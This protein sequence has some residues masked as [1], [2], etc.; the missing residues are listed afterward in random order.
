MAY[1]NTL[2][3][4]HSV[5]TDNFIGLKIA[6]GDQ[7]RA[8]KGEQVGNCKTFGSPYLNACAKK[9]CVDACCPDSVKTACNDPSDPTNPA[10][11][12]CDLQCST[13]CVASIDAAG[14][15]LKHIYGR[16]SQ[17][18]KPRGAITVTDWGQ[19]GVPPTVE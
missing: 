17:E 1:L 19:F 2:P 6:A 7:V 4:E 11:A 18:W 13:P 10:Y 15:I 3:A 8:E 5:P 14:Q 9:D 16:S 12:P